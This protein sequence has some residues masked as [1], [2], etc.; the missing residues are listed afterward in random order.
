MVEGHGEL[1][2]LQCRD[3][4]IGEIPI[5]GEGVVRKARLVL[6]RGREAMREAPVIAAHTDSPSWL[7]ITKGEQ[8]MEELGQGQHPVAFSAKG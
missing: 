7:D 6:D 8:V 2:G 4:F 3:Y 5:R 1:N